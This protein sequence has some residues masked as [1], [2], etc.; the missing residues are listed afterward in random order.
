MNRFLFRIKTV[1]NRSY[2]KIKS[3]FQNTTKSR[4]PDF[5]GLWSNTIAENTQVYRGLYSSLA[6]AADGT[7]KRPQRV[8]KEWVKRTEYNIADE[9]AK[10]SAQEVIQPASEKPES[11]QPVAEKLLAAVF[12]AGIN[13]D[14]HEVVILDERTTPAYVE[15]DGGE[16]YLGDMVEIIAGAWYKE[17]MLIEQGYCKST[18]GT[19]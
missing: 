1:V 17:G 10:S 4:K 9:A 7:A 14:A 16:L 5:V 12:D 15:W 19:E 2:Q 3:R 8:L 11:C 13:R 6:K 18:E